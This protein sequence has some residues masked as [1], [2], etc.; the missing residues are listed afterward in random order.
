M[1]TTAMSVFSMHLHVTC[2]FTQS[3]RPHSPKVTVVP[4]PSGSGG[5]GTYRHP[6][7]LPLRA[8]A[9]PGEAEAGRAAVRVVGGQ[10]ERALRAPVALLPESVRLRKDRAHVRRGEMG[11]DSLTDS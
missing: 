6:D 7:E 5:S 10:P 1:N 3:I 4:P 9:A 2:R 11:D 8:L